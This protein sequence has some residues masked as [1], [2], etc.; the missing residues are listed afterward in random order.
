[1]H[2]FLQKIG[3]S[4]AFMKERVYNEQTDRRSENEINKDILNI[5]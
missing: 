4:L 1:M 2:K 3:K 5:F